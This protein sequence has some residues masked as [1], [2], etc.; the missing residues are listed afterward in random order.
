[1][2]LLAVDRGNSR[3]KVGIQ[4]NNGVLQIHVFENAANDELLQFI[5][6]QKPDG[7]ILSSV[8][9]KDTIAIK[10]LFGGIEKDFFLLDYKTPLPLKNN[11]D[12]PETLGMDR[13]AGAIGAWVLAGKKDILLMDAGTCINYECVVN[14]TYLGGAIAPGLQMR[15]QAMHTFTGKLPS[16][17]LPE[18]TIDLTGQST[19]NCMLSG[20]VFGMVHE[21]H[22]IANAYMIEYPTLAVILTGGDA[23]YLGKYLKNSIFTPHTEV[24]LVGLMEILK[25]NLNVKN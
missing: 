9:S 14:H 15:L 2:K 3:T 22:G 19:T 8:V 7:A 12:T 23:P 17:V 4:E 10:T 11:Y 20:A 21:M 18:A 13:L 5:L 25:Y 16:V 6:D 24:T 1:M